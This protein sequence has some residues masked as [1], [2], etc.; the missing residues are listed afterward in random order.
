MKKHIISALFWFAFILVTGCY[1]DFLLREQ[2]IVTLRL[3]LTIAAW[4]GIIIGMIFCLYLVFMVRERI[5][6][7]QAQ[8]KRVQQV[9]DVY[10]IVSEAHG[11]FV[12]E[13]NPKA[14]WRPL[15]TIPNWQINSQP[16]EPSTVEIMTWQNWQSFHANHKQLA[17]LSPIPAQPLLPGSIDLLSALD[18]V[19]RCLI[20]GS[21][22]DVGKTSLLQHI[23]LRKQ[24]SSKV[25]VID[26]HTW[27]NKWPTG[28]VVGMGRNYKEIDQA[29]TALVRLMTKRYDEIG[30]GLV[31]EMG[32]NKITIIID[33]WRAIVANVKGASDAIKA[34]LTESRKAAFS[35][36]VATHSD[37]A[38][39][40]GLEG[41]YDLKD[42][43]T[44]VRLFFVGNGQR[45]ATLDTGNGE[46]PVTLPG[47]YSQV[48]EGEALDLKPEPDETEAE[49]LRRHQVGDS[50]SAIAQQVFGSKGGP[51]NQR[52]KDILEKFNQV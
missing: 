49:V 36:F 9:S 44:I 6:L 40:L 39:P 46:I 23:V 24:H 29:L 42:G 31:A 25:I 37:R 1:M 2:I 22:S 27:P 52:I 33:E 10:A 5:L 19:Q 41:E 20:V 7:K 30:K 17:A 16:T 48:V 4:I 51:Q 35:V 21:S 12:R 47:P 15:H 38:K 26:P 43:F 3:T 11:V 13:M 34:L 18:A 14:V 50:I 45:H 32:H 28:V 8:R